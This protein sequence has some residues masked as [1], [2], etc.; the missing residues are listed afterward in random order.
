M[1][2]KTIK[3]F[4]K[5]LI[6][7][8]ESRAIPDGALSASKNW[9]TKGDKME[10]R[11]GY[12]ILGTENSGTGKITGLH[13]T[14]NA[15]GTEIPVRTRDRKIEYYTAS[16]DTWTEISTNVL[17]TL[18]NNA[19]VSFA[20]YVSRAG[21][22]LWISAPNSGLIKILTANMGSHKDNF[23]ST[24]NYEGR[25]RIKLN[26]MFL[27]NRVK[28]K[29]GVY[30]SYIDT[31]TYTTVTA[32][33]LSDTASGTLA[34]VTGIRTCFG[35]SITDTSSGEVFTDNYDGTLTGSAGGTGTINYSTGAFTTNQSGAGEATYQWE[36]STTNGIADFTKS[37]TRTAGQGA[38]FRQDDNG[39]NLQTVLSYKDTEYC[40]HEFKTWGLTLGRDDTTATNLIFRGSAGIPNWRAAVETEDG[41]YYIDDVD[42]NDPR[43]RLMSYDEGSDQV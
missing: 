24:K 18:D 33:A 40:I 38:I 10:L 27:W 35:V 41:I 34:A 23:D 36:N 30:L 32:E 26:R 42:E 37:A 4:D 14:R 15:A 20:D 22:Q 43:F 31:E 1:L 25:I 29:S 12:K 7:R 21:Y 11:R 39:G 6:D 2:Q 5:G 13:V 16:S 17:D 8:L 3:V 9:V 28:D 19:D